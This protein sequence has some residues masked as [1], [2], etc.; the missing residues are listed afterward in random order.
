MNQ[1]NEN[2]K[3][4]KEK[5][6]K[7]RGLKRPHLLNELLVMTWKYVAEMWVKQGLE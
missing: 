1:R 2:Q 7:S 4:A 3:K 6:E 5:T